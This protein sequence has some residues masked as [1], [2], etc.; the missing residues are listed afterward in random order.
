M[1]EKATLTAQL[2]DLV[3]SYQQACIN[4]RASRRLAGISK[5]ITATKARLAEI[6]AFEAAVEAAMMEES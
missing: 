3:S 4:P 2:A 1:S 5:K 6:A